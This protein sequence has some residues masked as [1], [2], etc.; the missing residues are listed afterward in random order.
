MLGEAELERSRYIESQLEGR[1]SARRPARGTSSRSRG[2]YGGGGGGGGGG[3]VEDDGRS[4]GWVTDEPEPEYEERTRRPSSRHGGREQAGRAGGG[5][6]GRRPLSVGKRRPEAW[7]A[8]VSPGGGVSPRAAEV[9]SRSSGS[10]AAA[11]ALWQE[12]SGLKL[13]ALREESLSCGL[14]EDLVEDALESDSPKQAL[15]ELLVEEHAAATRGR[16]KSSRSGGR[17][18]RGKV[19]SQSGGGRSSRRVARD[20]SPTA[21]RVQTPGGRSARVGKSPGTLGREIAAG[22]GDQSR[23]TDPDRPAYAPRGGQR[24]GGKGRRGGREPETPPLR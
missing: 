6:S 3:W 21:Q 18:E 19:S 24:D 5:G 15:I 2:N 7:E 16:H 10:S 4:D 12:L 11:A 1:R 13:L 20:R 17:K 22:W 23:S 14:S 8:N 9:S